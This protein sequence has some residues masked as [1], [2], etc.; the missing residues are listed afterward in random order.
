MTDTASETTPEKDVRSKKDEEQRVQDVM[1]SIVEEGI[2]KPT[3]A[4]YALMAYP[5]ATK[6]F[7]EKLSDGALTKVKGHIVPKDAA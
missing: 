7:V 3:A 2:D 4:K 5:K 6:P 1:D